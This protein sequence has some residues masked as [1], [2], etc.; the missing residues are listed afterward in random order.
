MDNGS[1]DGSVGLVGQ[2]YPEV[3]VLVPRDTRSFFSGAV[4]AGIAAARADLVFLLNND[5][6]ADERCLEE[7]VAA[8]AAHPECAHGRRQDAAL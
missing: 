1:T 7:L 5:T 3:R 8:M 2:H 4:N 6:E